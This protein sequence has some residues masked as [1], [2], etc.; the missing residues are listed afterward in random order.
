MIGFQGCFFA[1]IK[2]RAVARFYDVAKSDL[3]M[4]A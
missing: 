1:Y 2:K 4:E 3:E